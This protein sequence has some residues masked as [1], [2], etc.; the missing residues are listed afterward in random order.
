MSFPTTA[1]LDTAT[2]A[3]ENPANGWTGP[4]Y[5]SDGTLKILSNALDAAGAGNGSAYWNAGTVGPASEVYAT[6]VALGALDLRIRSITPDTTSKDGYLLYVNGS[7]AVAYYRLDNEVGTQLG[8]ND[9]QTIAATDSAGISII[10]SALQAYYKVGAGAWA[11]VG[12]G[13]T[14]GTY[15]GAGYLGAALSAA[16]T[17]KNFGGG[18]IPASSIAS[19]VDRH[20]RQRRS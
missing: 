3:D 5:A 6:I 11:A 7:T 10:G 16:V 1:I 15:S 13:R 18:T 4:L 8:S 20:F 14:D 19:I 2:R 9:L 17:I 12:A